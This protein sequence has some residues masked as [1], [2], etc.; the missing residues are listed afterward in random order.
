MTVP[1]LLLLAEGR[2]PRPRKAPVSRPKELV[3]HMQ[4]ATLLRAHALPEWQWTHIASGELRDARTAGKLKQMGLRPGWPDFALVS[5]AGIFHALEL[6][7]AGGK[8]SEPQENFRVWCIRSG[9]P[10]AVCHDMR[11]VLVALD[12]WRCLH[13][14]ALEL[15]RPNPTANLTIGER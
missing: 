9:T 3:L 12:A 6:K 1:P 8:L 7:R 10:Y 13:N 5:P 2:K 11:E 4:V 14:Q 15:A